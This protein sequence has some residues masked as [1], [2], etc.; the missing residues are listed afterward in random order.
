M[1]QDNNSNL[2]SKFYNKFNFKN[3][4]L[5]GQDGIVNV[6]GLVLGVA[7]ATS[8]STIVI[9]SGIVGATSFLLL[10]NLGRVKE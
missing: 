6:L 7:S 5:G 4:I 1:V 8:S 9:I 2:V 3:L 10:F